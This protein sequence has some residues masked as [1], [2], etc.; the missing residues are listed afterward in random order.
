MNEEKK[1]GI[2]FCEYLDSVDSTNTRAR[3]YAE[4]GGD[5][6]ALFVA[7]S[8]TAGRGRMGRSFFSPEGTGLYYSLLLPYPSRTED[9]LRLTGAAAVVTAEAIEAVYGIRTGIKWVNDIYLDGKKLAG[10]LAES[11][12]V[13][14]KRYALIGIGINLYTERF[15]EELAE[16]AI[17]LCPGMKE[18]EAEQKRLALIEDLTDRLLSLAK[19]PSDPS[20]F[21]RYRERSLVLGRSV[22][23]TRNGVTQEGVA[24]EID[25]MGALTVRLADGTKQL[26]SSGEITLR[27]QSKS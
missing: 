5:A 10:L 21:S 7:R 22:R 25:S 6:P 8:Q 2:A 16:L 9:A 27:L 11:F 26:L 20:Y 24:E 14:E 12:S 18:T 15:P 13:G 4:G 23:F 1:R 3:Q 17:S 19:D